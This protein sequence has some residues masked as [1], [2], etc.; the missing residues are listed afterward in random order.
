MC[1]GYCGPIVCKADR[2]FSR[3]FRVADRPLPFTLTWQP[4]AVNAALDVRGLDKAYAQVV[5][6][7]GVSF[8]VATGTVHG[9]LGRSE[10]RRVGKECV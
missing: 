5:A 4:Q 10:E 1:R 6:L 7:D 9:L 3:A 2:L 8:T